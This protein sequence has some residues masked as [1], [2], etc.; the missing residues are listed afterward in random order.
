MSSRLSSPCRSAAAGFRPTALFQPLGRVMINS[1]L[2][3][4][5]H[6]FSII[7]GYE[8]R[9]FGTLSNQQL[10][11]KLMVRSKNLSRIVTSL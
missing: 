4:T 5:A 2:S 8:G 6:D 1:P 7:D 11:I 3:K 10:L 9:Y